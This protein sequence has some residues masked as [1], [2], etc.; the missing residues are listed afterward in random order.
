MKLFTS[1]GKKSEDLINLGVK[2]KDSSNFFNF[3]Y[4]SNLKNSFFPRNLLD[5]CYI[6]IGAK[7]KLNPEIFRKTKKT[8]TRI[9]F[10]FSKTMKK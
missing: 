6:S 5:R 1:L 10:Y 4:T 2:N 8:M 7:F 3:R 9:I